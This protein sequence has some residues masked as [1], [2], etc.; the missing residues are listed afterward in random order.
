MPSDARFAIGWM[1]DNKGEIGHV[2]LEV[3]ARMLAVPYQFF[4]RIERKSWGQVLEEQL[5]R[6]EK[7]RSVAGRRRRDGS[8]IL[9]ARDLGDSLLL[10]ILV[11][12][13]LEEEEPIVVHGHGFIACHGTRFR[14][15]RT[16]VFDRLPDAKRPWCNFAGSVSSGL[17]SFDICSVLKPAQY[18]WRAG[19]RETANLLHINVAERIPYGIIPGCDYDTGRVNVIEIQVHARP[20]KERGSL[21]EI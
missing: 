13:F 17:K 11:N 18:H 5:R 9:E 4:H 7:R 14:I 12:L 21:S 10:T 15:G 16:R 6:G 1:R 8:E 3:A 19:F 2:M 20:V